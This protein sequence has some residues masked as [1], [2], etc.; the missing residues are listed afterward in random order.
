MKAETVDGA[1]TQSRRALATGWLL[2]LPAMAVL[3]FFFLVPAAISL[4]F[5]LRDWNGISDSTFIGLRNFSSLGAS[6]RFWHALWTNLLYA[7]LTLV[8]QVP[9]AFLLAYVLFRRRSTTPFLRALVLFPQ[10]LSIGAAGL[11]WLMIY[12]PQRGLLNYALSAVL[13]DR[14]A[15]AWLGTP[16]TALI[17]VV[18]AANWYYFG[19]H[20]LI[21]MAGMSGI[22][23][24]YYDVLKLSSARVLDELRYLILPLLRE[25]ML[26]SFLLVMSG[27]F[28]QVLGFI[29]LLTNGG[30]SGSTELLGLYSI[31]IGFRAGRFGLASAVTV[32]LIMLV[33]SIVIWPILRIARTRLEYT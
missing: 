27:S 10:V 16:E 30:P 32:V 3:T 26:I 22:P 24:D 23:Q 6:P 13:Q 31:E 19:L 25:Q 7:G 1:R 11:L 9:L 14:I 8:T 21:F 18:V 5:S 20:T 17:A 2:N 4:W 12:H 33:V 28:G 29:S 15:I